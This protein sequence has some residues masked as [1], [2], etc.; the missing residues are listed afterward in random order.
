MGGCGLGAGSGTAGSGV[1]GLI[2]VTGCDAFD[3]SGSDAIG[4]DG[5]DAIG[6]A[7]F[8]A[9]GVADFDAIGVAGFG[10]T[11]VAGFGVAADIERTLFA[12]SAD[13]SFGVSRTALAGCVGCVSHE[14]CRRNVFAISCMLF[15]CVFGFRYRIEMVIIWVHM[16]NMMLMM[17]MS[18]C[19]DGTQ[20]YDALALQSNRHILFYI[21]L[22]LLLFCCG[23]GGD[24]DE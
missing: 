22:V 24:E 3:V 12:L 11:A 9:I 10:V 19:T 4:V 16:V 15:V 20:H 14:L 21:Q 23:R 6:V 17:L 8:D 13:P 5:F 18:Y 1:G 2:G 7:G